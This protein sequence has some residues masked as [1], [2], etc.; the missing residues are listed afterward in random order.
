MIVKIKTFSG[1]NLYLSEEDYLDEVM[2]SDKLSKEEKI[3]LGIGGAGAAVGAGSAGYRQWLAHK[4]LKNP[5]IVDAETTRLANSY[6]DAKFMDKVNRRRRVL[7]G[8]DARKLK[9]IE[10]M[11]LAEGK[12]IGKNAMKA[13]KLGRYGAIGGAAVGAAGLGT[14]YALSKRDKKRR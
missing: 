12:K 3:A 7:T 13:G 10:A 6:G 1:E 4:I 14:A 8:L 5:G 11:Q 2:Y 9:D